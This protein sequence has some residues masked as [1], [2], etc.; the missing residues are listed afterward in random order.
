VEVPLEP[1]SRRVACLDEAPSR[2]A[3]LLLTPPK[4]VDPR[5]KLFGEAILSDRERCRGDDVVEGREL[6]QAGVVDERSDRLV[7]VGKDRDRASVPRGGQVRRRSVDRD[8]RLRVAIPE[9]ELERRVVETGPEAFLRLGLRGRLRDVGEQSPHRR[10]VSRDRGALARHRA[11]GGTS[12]GARRVS[13]TRSFGQVP[14][15][16]ARASTGVGVAG[17]RKRGAGRVERFVVV[18]ARA[19]AANASAETSARSATKRIP[20]SWPR[21]RHTWRTASC[22]IWN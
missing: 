10:L 9:E 21:N 12:E 4:L 19:S 16:E 8:V 11:H 22:R 20:R 18:G 5:V 7:G 13:R 1:P 6:D 3:D 2:L 15:R 14:D 17:A